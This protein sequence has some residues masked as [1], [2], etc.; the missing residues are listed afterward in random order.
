MA[1][2]NQP[3]QKETGRINERVEKR[4]NIG[5]AKGSMENLQKAAE[6]PPKTGSGGKDK[7]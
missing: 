4:S 6:I 7:K 1:K 2:K 5:D 3:R